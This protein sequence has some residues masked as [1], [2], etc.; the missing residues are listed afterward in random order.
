MFDDKRDYDYF[1]PSDTPASRSLICGVITASREENRAA[2]RRLSSIADLFE[3]RRAERGEHENWA[4]DTWAAVGA[5]VAAALR[6]SLG[7][8]GSYM[9]YGLAMLRLPDIA[10]LFA[11]GDI[12]M[13]TFATIVY[14]TELVTDA[15]VIARLD[16]ILA[17]RAARWPSL[18]RGHLIREIDRL[19]AELD[20]DA[21]RRAKDRARDRNVSLWDYR[22][23]MADLSGRL[24]ATDAQLLDQKL[25]ALAATVCEADPRTVAQ[26]R[27]DALGALAAGA[28]RLMCQCAGEHCP[29]A[30]ATATPTSVVIHVVA[31]RS[32]LNGDSDQPGYLLGADVLISAEL[33]RDLAAHARLRPLAHPSDRPAEPRYQ[34]SRA[35]AD[36]VRARD[37]TCR[38]P[39]CDKPATVCDLDHTVPYPRGDTHASNL[40][41]LCRF[42]HLLKTFWNWQD[43][44]LP[45][46]TV[47]WTLPDGQTYV[48]TPGSA[49]LFPMLMTPTGDPPIREEEPDRCGDRTVFMPLR[50]TT[51]SANRAHRIAGERGH[52]GRLG[53]P[54]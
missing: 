48:T 7:K 3:L 9:N 25:D 47:I 1:E 6:I 24:F 35:L 28:Q 22:D 16:H 11:A 21:V 19:V 15:A 40:K 10:T 2:A 20:P 12:D 18:T 17:A 34:P 26:R 53:A 37:L 32:T 42:H 52:G 8:A 14:R 50:K 46:G 4:V 29:A 33:L 44:Q 54:F 13:Q 49:M 39:G 43:R 51:R 30:A 27:A 31:E 38:A 41:A 36:F 23:G 45:D 5:E